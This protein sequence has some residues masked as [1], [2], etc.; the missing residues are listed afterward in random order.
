MQS[1]N[2]LPLAAVLDQR[3]FC[4]HGGIS[5]DLNVLKDIDGV[6]IEI[7]LLDNYH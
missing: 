6:C 5:P 3:F 7:Y 4:V 2:A 1:F